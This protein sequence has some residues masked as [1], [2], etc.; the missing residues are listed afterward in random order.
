MMSTVVE[1]IAPVHGS[2]ALPSSVQAAVDAACAR[3]APTWPL[4]TKAMAA[5]MSGWK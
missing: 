5:T 2:P 4:V 3:I 1:A